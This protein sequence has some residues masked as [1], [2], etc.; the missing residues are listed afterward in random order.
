MKK[1][2]LTTM[3]TTSLV[4]P[5]IMNQSAEAATNLA[6]KTI[7]APPINKTT[8]TQMKKGIY[9]YQGVGLGMT[10][11][12]VEAKIGKNRM[13]SGMHDK[14]DIVGTLY[15]GLYGKGYKLAL[16][17]YDIN[18]KTKFNDSKMAVIV[19]DLENKNITKK[20]LEQFTGK[21]TGYEGSLKS[22]T[23]ITRDYNRLSVAYYKEKGVWKVGY[24]A[25]I[26]PQNEVGMYE[27]GYK[28]GLTLPK[29]VVIPKDYDQELA[30]EK[31]ADA[32]NEQFNK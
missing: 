25:Q 30:I 12:E 10:K 19:M 5:I 9:K 1:L 16:H 23:T 11:A 17:Y 4:S 15:S 27:Y 8:I 21:A 28:K 32:L 14:N 2:L 22:K 13:G 26:S 24:I 29:G 18:Y 7:S 6:K 3:I 20:Q 31:A